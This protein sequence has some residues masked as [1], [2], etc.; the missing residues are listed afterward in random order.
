VAAPSN[1]FLRQQAALKL[2]LSERTESRPLR[3]ILENQSRDSVAL[4]VG[5]EGGWTEA[6]FAA[7][8]GAGFQEASLGS[9]ILR[10]ETAVTAC[11]AAVNY[12][13]EK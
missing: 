9:L 13:L 2:M 5:P 4:A 3:G 11:L 8:R 7:A 10:T 1:A 12:A 6:E